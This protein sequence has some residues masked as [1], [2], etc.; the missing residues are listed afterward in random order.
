M[1]QAPPEAWRRPDV[2]LCRLLCRLAHNRP[3]GGAGYRP[4]NPSSPP[5]CSLQLCQGDDGQHRRGHACQEC[6]EWNVR[7]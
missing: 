4:T 3:T 1:Q 5:L 7:R 2:L 6:L